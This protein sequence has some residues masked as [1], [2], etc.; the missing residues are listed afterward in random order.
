[1]TVRI[2]LWLSVILL[3]CQGPAPDPFKDEARPVGMC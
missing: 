2:L 1:M 3:A